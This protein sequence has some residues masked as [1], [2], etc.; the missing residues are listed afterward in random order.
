MGTSILIVDDDALLRRSLAFNL[1]KAGFRASAAA[2]AEDAL[3]AVR[4][5][6]PDLVLLDIGLPG[7]DGLDALRELRRQMDVPVIFLSARRRELDQVLGL[8]MGADDYITKPFDI[9]VLL[10]HIKAV[11]RRAAPSRPATP[12]PLTVGDLT[13]DPAAHVVTL[14]GRTVE[15]S[16]REFDLLHALALEAGRVLSVDDLLA[17]VWGAE[18]EGEP[19]VVYVHIRWLR[20]KLEEDPRRPQRILTV[21][22][23]GYKFAAPA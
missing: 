6:P 5:D 7:M 18:Y 22:R 21:R 8:G 20:E 10:A 23:V 15:L 1:E 12:A 16:P 4:V 13:V 2:T 19:Q 9:D 17:R 3:A 14:A 11:L